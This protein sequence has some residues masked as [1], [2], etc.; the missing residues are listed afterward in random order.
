[1]LVC[2]VSLRPA[3]RA[4]AATIAE[5]ATATD[6]ATTGQVVFAILV[7]DPVSALD[8]VDAYLGEIMR[9]AASA[10]ATV[11]AGLVYVAAV[12]ETTIA[13]ATA[14]GA[15]PAIYSGTVAEAATA[16]ATQDASTTAAT[17]HMRVIS[18]SIP[19]FGSV[20]VTDDNSGK[21]QVIANIGVVK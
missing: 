15:V 18:A 2:N 16:S 3:R 10:A 19:G 14:D 5:T 6:G 9:E 17:A 8:R 7:D 4:I 11:D 13:A 21:T 20:V 1:M 12:D